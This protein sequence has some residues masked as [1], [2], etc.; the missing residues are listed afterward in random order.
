M[1]LQDWPISDILAM[2]RLLS[3]SYWRLCPIYHLKPENFV[4][5]SGLRLDHIMRYD[6]VLE[7]EIDREAKSE[8]RDVLSSVERHGP[9]VDGFAVDGTY[10]DTDRV[11]YLGSR[12]LRARLDIKVKLECTMMTFSDKSSHLKLPTVRFWSR[13]RRVSKAYWGGN[14]KYLTS[15]RFC[16]IKYA[17]LLSWV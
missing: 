9:D 13:Q 14:V 6:E 17:E 7:V 4:D 10:S 2:P 8:M 12:E 16:L 3:R 15:D 11:V 5:F 1:A